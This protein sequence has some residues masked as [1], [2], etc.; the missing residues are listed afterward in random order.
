LLND[1]L[2]AR[3][4]IR[5][6]SRSGIAIVGKRMAAVVLPAAMFWY[7]SPYVFCWLLFVVKLF[8]DW[9]LT[10][11]WAVVTDIRGQATASVFAF[12]H[13]VAGLGLIVAPVLFG[14]L[15]EHYGWRPVSLAVA[16]TYVL[17]AL[18]WLLID[19]TIPVIGPSSTPRAHRDSS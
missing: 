5:R 1:W 8:G 14:S 12:N 18:S 11:S 9:S 19:C 17:C 16:A 4:G 13:A 3:T 2:I 10:T 15:A 6:W 7:D